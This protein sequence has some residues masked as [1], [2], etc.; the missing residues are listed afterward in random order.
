MTHIQVRKLLGGRTLYAGR[1]WWYEFRQL[2]IRFDE[3]LV[4]RR[5]QNLMQ[6]LA[7]LTKNWNA[8]LN[9]E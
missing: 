5:A 8:D 1:D 3:K 9:S 2:P 4:S 7:P 6:Q